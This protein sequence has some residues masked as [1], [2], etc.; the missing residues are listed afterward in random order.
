MDFCVV[1]QLLCIHTILGINFVDCSF[2]VILILFLTS[3][4]FF[5]VSY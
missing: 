4:Y 2:V 5:E 1:P 3:V